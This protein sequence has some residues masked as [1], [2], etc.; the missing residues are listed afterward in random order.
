MALEFRPYEPD[1]R[2]EILALQKHLWGPH[3]DVNSEFFR[4]KYEV[5]P[6]LAEP[7]VYLALSQGKVVG[8]RGFM[9]ML[10]EGPDD[11]PPLTLP[12]AADLVVH[13]DHRSAA[14]VRKMMAFALADMQE[15]GHPFVMNMSGIKFTLLSSIRMGWKKVA[16]CQVGCW[17][18][19]SFRERRL[20]GGPQRFMELKMTE[21]KGHPFGVLDRKVSQ[22]ASSPIRV[23]GHPRPV[24]MA[25][26]IKGLPKTSRI[27]HVRDET[28]F[29]WRFGNSL[30]EYRFFFHGQEELQ[31]YLILE[32]QRRRTEMEARVVDWE[33]KDTHVARDLLAAAVRVNGLKYL[34][35]WFGT[36]QP[37]RDQLLLEAG[38]ERVPEEKR[39]ARTTKQGILVK[40][41]G[42]D[43]ATDKEEILGLSMMEDTN[44][45]LRLLYSDAG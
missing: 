35:A 45:D 42:T 26:L 20:L 12:L 3:L 11:E 38:F 25:K 34:T 39:R 13:P 4:W 40:C 18:N 30:S 41:L 33:A 7:N 15:K 28:Y 16:T 36:H 43:G 24:E 1:F 37:E 32:S 23:Q 17:T 2:G 21:K 9:G 10:W 19:T 44:W 14:I 22:L 6:Y 29:A 8:M 5:N 27:R 31:G